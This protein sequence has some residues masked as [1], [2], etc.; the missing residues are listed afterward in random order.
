MFPSL[1]IRSD[2]LARAMVEVAVQ[3]TGEGQSLVFENR[4]IKA[5][6]HPSAFAH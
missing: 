4:D 2:D 1:V 5:L 6:A 3:R